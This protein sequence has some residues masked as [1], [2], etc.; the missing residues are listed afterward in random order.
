MKYNENDRVSL[1]PDLD[2]ERKD[3]AIQGNNQYNFVPSFNQW[4]S[5]EEQKIK[6]KELEKNTKSGL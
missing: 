6:S 2:L 4:T 3:K 5:M 1:E